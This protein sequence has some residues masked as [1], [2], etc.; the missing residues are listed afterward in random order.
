LWQADD[1]RR[2]GRFEEAVE[3]LESLVARYPDEEDAYLQMT[4]IFAR[5]FADDTRALAS[6][7]RGVKAVPYSFALRND[8]GY[9]LLALGRYPE[10]I[11]EF[12]IYAQLRPDEPNP[13]DSLAE[14]YLVSGNP[15]HA[16]KQYT[17]AL[18]LNPSFAHAHT[19]R[20]WALG[21][22]GR[23][24]DAFV[25][26]DRLAIASAAQ[27]YPPADLQFL[28]AF[29]VSRVGQYRK[30]A[31]HLAA[32]LRQAAALKDAGSVTAF[33]LLSAA[34]AIERGQ[35]AEGRRSAA[36]AEASLR[37]IHDA[38]LR[39]VR[40][41]Y[42]RSLQG[43]VN[44]RTGHL[45]AARTELATLDA[46]R[47]PDSAREAWA[48][49]LLRGEIALAS[50]DPAAA[51]RAFTLG[52]PPVKMWFS[53]GELNATVLA[54]GLSLRDGL[55]RAKTAQ[56]DLTSAIDQYHRLLT[57]DVSQKWTSMLEPRYVLELARLIERTGH[58]AEAT[59]EYRR[60][61]DLWRT[62]DPAS[63]EATEA[64]AAISAAGTGSRR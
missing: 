60:F 58:T 64:T 40:E 54:N 20:I 36:A 35:F 24:D 9:R 15:E 19:G 25:E 12:K 43:I 47:A 14:A 27:Q 28:A 32:G 48:A 52:E 41:V 17:R 57:V 46:L 61:L 2:Q 31:Q 33:N 37:H 8:Y 23:Y 29:T 56:G 3:L 42:T 16:L 11:R 5:E 4:I 13:H 21:T 38:S 50:G 30:A 1:A 34:I 26:L 44:A 7:E 45:D 63:P 51:E 22:M 55:A 59:R 6:A 53:M 49:Q 18:E 10:A 62:A 39:R